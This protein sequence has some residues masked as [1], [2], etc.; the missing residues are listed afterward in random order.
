MT[1]SFPPAPTLGTMPASMEMQATAT[2][3]DPPEKFTARVPLHESKQPDYKCAFMLAV[4]VGFDLA[5]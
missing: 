4:L 3:G 2:T 1:T 5:E